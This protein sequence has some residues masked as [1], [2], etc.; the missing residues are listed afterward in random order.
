MNKQLFAQEKTSPIDPRNDSAPVSFGEPVHGLG[1]RREA[2]VTQKQLP[3]WKAHSCLGNSS[4]VLS[5]ACLLG[6]L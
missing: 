3:H 4:Q 2:G 6:N 5:H 1:L